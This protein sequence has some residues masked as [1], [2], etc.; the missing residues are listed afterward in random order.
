[1]S[2]P[3][4]DTSM[5]QEAV[6]QAL[7]LQPNST[8]LQLSYHVWPQN[9]D[10]QLDRMYRSAMKVTVSVVDSMPKPDLIHE[11]GNLLPE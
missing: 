6:I 10:E 5:L 8:A 2:F 7:R 1:M 9:P 4:D 3:P 11:Q